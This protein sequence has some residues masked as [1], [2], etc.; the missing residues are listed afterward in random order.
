MRKPASGLQGH[1]AIEKAVGEVLTAYLAS[2]RS[3][4]LAGPV[5]SMALKQGNWLKAAATLHAG[6]VHAL[7]LVE[8]AQIHASALDRLTAAIR[9]SSIKRNRR[10]RSKG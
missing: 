10:C 3:D 2:D 7:A 5:G 4:Y 8:A 6:A 1:E 9:A